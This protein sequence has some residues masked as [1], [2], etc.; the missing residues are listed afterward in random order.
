M[1]GVNP[2]DYIPH[3]R[4][5]D[6]YGSLGRQLRNEGVRIGHMIENMAYKVDPFYVWN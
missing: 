4:H 1:I 6:V 5:Y 3:F 2:S